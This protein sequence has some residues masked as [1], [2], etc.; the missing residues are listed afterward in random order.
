MQNIVVWPQVLVNQIKHPCGHR[1]Q[2][3]NGGQTAVDKGIGR[4]N[5][6]DSFPPFIV[7]SGVFGQ[8]MNDTSIVIAIVQH[9][10][11]ILTT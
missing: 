8:Y 3:R 2:V 7:R 5:V 9:N 11:Y 6:H 4:C 1:D 10:K